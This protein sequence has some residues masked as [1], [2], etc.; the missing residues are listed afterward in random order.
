MKLTLNH[1]YQ[2]LVIRGKSICIWF[3]YHGKRCREILKGWAAT[4]ANIRKASSLRSLIVSE[5]NLGA[6]NCRVRFPSYRKNSGM[7]TPL[8]I[9]K[10]S[11]LCEAWLSIKKTE[12]TANTIRKRRSQLRTLIQV[13]GADTSI[14]DISHSNILNYRVEILEG[15]TLYDES[16]RSSKK[17][18]SVR[19][20]ITTFPC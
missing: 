16:R 10:F 1:N 12:L 8:A 14:A 6:F 20:V 4:P 17:G 3:M 13:I 9:N 18:R 11:E 5:I 7:A 19:T 2:S 15:V